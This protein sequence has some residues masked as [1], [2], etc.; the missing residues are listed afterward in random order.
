MDRD[1]ALRLLKGGEDGVREWNQRREQG[2]D[3]PDLSVADLRG[4]DL[5]GAD[6]S[7]AHLTKAVLSAAHLRGA[8]LRGADLRGAKLRGADLDS[9]VCGL[10]DFVDV[11][12]SEVK[13][14]ESI[15]HH[16]PST[17]GVD[18]LVRSHGRI[19]KAFLRGCGVPATLIDDLL[20]LF[21]GM[22]P[23]DL[24]TTSTGEEAGREGPPERP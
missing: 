4:A 16:L 3:I 9:A 18:T 17:V 8:D 7:S 22:E 5:R 15:Q 10:T 19:P 13:G 12:L 14:L 20:S 11:D 21:R 24:K 23:K 2:E 1:E 6:L